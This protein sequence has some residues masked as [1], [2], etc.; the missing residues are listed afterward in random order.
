[1]I[2]ISIALASLL[3]ATS[4]AMAQDAPPPPPP[5]VATTPPPSPPST[6]PP[7]PP[8]GAVPATNP[9]V[10]QGVV[11]DANAGRSFMIPTALTAPAGTWSIS[12]Y[13]LFA[14]GFNYAIT[15]QI[16]VGAATLIPISST[17]PLVGLLTAKW[18]LIRSGALRLAAN[19]NFGFNLGTSG[20]TAGG[21]GVAGGVATL[22][23]DGAC[24]SHASAYVGVGFVTS[25]QSGA[26]LV[27]AGSIAGR[28]GRHVKLLAEVD[29]GAILG[30]AYN[31]FA[32]GF[33]LWYGVRFTSHN[34]G[35]DLGLVLPVYNDSTNGW[36]F[37]YGTDSNGGHVLP[38]GAP[39][40]SFSYRGG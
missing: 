27:F 16:D 14:I 40:F 38:F 34:I 37:G 25:G 22:C 39:F 26:P 12:D 29:S 35:V 33:L 11:E 8:P 24:H 19:V 17:E 23:L 1:M 5:P 31:S 30:S 36:T 3:A 15:D 10:D 18:Q 32:D 21:G 4:V 13:E 9:N 7:P 20:T 2:R 6:T 28:V